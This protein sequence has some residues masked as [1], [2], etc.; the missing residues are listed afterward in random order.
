MSICIYLWY[1][2]YDQNTQVQH[3]WMQ[4]QTKVYLWKS[5]TWK[6]WLSYLNHL[7]EFQ[8]MCFQTCSLNNSTHTTHQI[9]MMMFRKK[10]IRKCGSMMAQIQWLSCQWYFTYLPIGYFTIL[11][12]FLSSFMEGLCGLIY[13]Q[14][15]LIICLFFKKKLQ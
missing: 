3:L 4:N 8:I 11:L 15:K 5:Q 10:Q 7:L 6:N 13:L 9:N 12:I 14:V 1:R 2:K